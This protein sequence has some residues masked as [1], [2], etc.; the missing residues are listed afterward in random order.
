MANWTK[1]QVAATIDHAAL[2]PTM[3]DKD[4]GFWLRSMNLLQKQLT[5]LVGMRKG[6]Q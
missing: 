6:P 3:T 2:K 4:L 5:E 1:A